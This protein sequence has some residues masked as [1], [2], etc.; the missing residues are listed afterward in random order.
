MAFRL[1]RRKILR[2]QNAISEIF[3]AYIHVDSIAQK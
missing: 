2:L 3:Y 1:L